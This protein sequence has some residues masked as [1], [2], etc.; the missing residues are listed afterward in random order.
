MAKKYG[1]IA[2][3]NFVIKLTKKVEFFYLIVKPLLHHKMIR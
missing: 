1:Q 3:N 2:L